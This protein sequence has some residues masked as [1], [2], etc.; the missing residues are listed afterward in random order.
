MLFIVNHD[1]EIGL[2]W[3]CLFWD[4]LGHRHPDHRLAINAYK[5]PNY[6]SGINCVC[7]PTC[8]PYNHL[9][10]V[11][12]LKACRYAVGVLS[13]AYAIFNT[14]ML[15]CLSLSV[16][17]DRGCCSEWNCDTREQTI[18]RP[19]SVDPHRVRSI[20]GS[21]NN[22]TGRCRPNVRFGIIHTYLR[23]RLLW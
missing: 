13:S 14:L 10:M 15:L 1:P 6:R 3:V 22:L 20:D 23:D 11:F 9:D 19:Q 7:M 2:K 17:D 4:L 21:Q 5:D 18:I 12:S 8:S 16:L